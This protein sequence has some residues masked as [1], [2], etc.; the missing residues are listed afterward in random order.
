MQKGFVSARFWKNKTIGIWAFLTVWYIRTKLFF[1]TDK[2]TEKYW[3]RVIIC[4][5]LNK[6]V[7]R[8]L[9]K[10]EATYQVSARSVSL[11]NP[12]CLVLEVMEATSQCAPAITPCFLHVTARAALLVFLFLL[13]QN[14]VNN[15]EHMEAFPHCKLFWGGKMWFANLVKWKRHFQMLL[16][17][18]N[19]SLCVR[20]VLQ[21]FCFVC[22]FLFKS[23]WLP[24]SRIKKFKA[25]IPLVMAPGRQEDTLRLLFLY[26]QPPH[27]GL[28]HYPQA[29][30]WCKRL[31]TRKKKAA[32]TQ[33]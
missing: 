12:A 11:E 31:D 26:P 7:L 22:L 6:F 16:R 28:F 19:T 14:D 13:Q 9:L 29:T 33:L 18:S 1:S 4:R 23:L 24:P 27:W 32:R 17:C 15:L 3:H 25:L 20:S 21:M 2:W 5:I 8:Y 30:T 10:T